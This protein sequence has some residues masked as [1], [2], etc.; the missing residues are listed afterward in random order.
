M[1]KIITGIRAEG[2]DAAFN[3]AWTKDPLEAIY[4]YGTDYKAYV[5]AGATSFIVEDVSADLAILAEE[6]NGYHMGYDHRKF[7]HHE[8]AAALMA[9]KAH[10]PDTML[11]PL[12]MIR[13]TLE[14]WDVLHHMPT[15][16]QRAAATN[17][18]NFIVREGKRP[19]PV[20]NGPHFCLADGLTP[21]EWRLVRIAWDNGYTAEPYA[22]P[23]VTVLWS[24]QRMYAEL[25]ELVKT[26]RW[27]TAKWISE[28]ASR[29]APVHKIVNIKDL[30][31]VTGPLLVTNPELLPAEELKS[32]LAYKGGPLLLLGGRLETGLSS[33]FEISMENGWGSVQFTGYGELKTFENIK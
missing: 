9:N 11:T 25:E 2:K 10:M 18:N 7:V 21:E 32:V 23:G 1:T 4:R 24:E 3:S 28:L 16:M 20:T 17:L 13:D 19:E 27:H 15:A 30:N 26:K 8:F 33:K 22:I 14:Q 29:G 6:E 12:F 31:A 5:D